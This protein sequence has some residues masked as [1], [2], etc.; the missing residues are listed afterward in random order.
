MLVEKLAEMR[1]SAGIQTAGEEIEADAA[2]IEYAM[3]EGTTQT[4][5]PGRGKGLPQMKRLIKTFGAGHLMVLSRGG[6]YLYAS[7]AG[8]Y[9][10]TLSTP[11]AGTLVEWEVEVPRL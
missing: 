10:E 4:D 8:S 11:V 6:M 2:A 1:Q 3:R 7:D 5:E 9:T